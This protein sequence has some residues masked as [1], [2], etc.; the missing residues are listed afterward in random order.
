MN[1][2]IDARQNAST[3]QQ[4]AVKDKP[5]RVKTRCGIMG[6]DLLLFPDKE[7]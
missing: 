7:L 1:Q 4:V 3:I 5:V 6:W 2:G